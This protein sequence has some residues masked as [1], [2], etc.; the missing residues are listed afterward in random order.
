MGL[1]EMGSTIVML[2]E[3]PKDTKISKRPGDKVRLG[4]NLI[5]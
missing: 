1:F 2:F 5:I 4:D 3:C